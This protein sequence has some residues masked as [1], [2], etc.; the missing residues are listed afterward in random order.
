MS[1][2][3]D[4]AG[5]FPRKIAIA[6]RLFGKELHQK[7]LKWF[8]LRRAD[9]R[10]GE[11][12]V[13]AGVPS[14]HSQ[15]AQ[16]VNQIDIRLTS[17]R[18]HEQKSS[19]TYGEKVKVWLNGMVRAVRIAALERNRRNVLKQL[20]A[21]V[22]KS[23]SPNVLRTGEAHSAKQIAETIGSID[24]AIR[25]LRASTYVWARR[26]LLASSLLMILTIVVLLSF[27]AATQQRFGSRENSSSSLSEDQV[28]TL[29]TQTATFREQLLR[30][31]AELRRQE[32]ESTQQRI[33]AVE[34][35]HKEQRDRERAE[36]QK[37]AREQA[38][39]DE[40]ARRE[41]AD[42]EKQQQQLA[43]AEQARLEREEAEAEKLARE[44]AERAAAAERTRKEEERRTAQ[45]AEEKR[46]HEQAGHDTQNKP[47]NDL[48]R[49]QIEKGKASAAAMMGNLPKYPF[50]YDPE[51]LDKLYEGRLEEIG[52]NRL[53]LVAVAKAFQRAGAIELGRELISGITVD[54][55]T[56]V[57]MHPNYWMT[58]GI[59]DATGGLEGNWG[60]TTSANLMRVLRDRTEGKFSSNTGDTGKAAWPL[61]MRLVVTVDDSDFKK[62]MQNLNDTER[63]AVE[64]QIKELAAKGAKVY[65][66]DYG[67]P[68][69]RS[70]YND[71]H[72]AFW[73]GDVPILRRDLLAVSE[74]HPLANLGN[75]A[76]TDVPQ[77]LGEANRKHAEALA[78]A[79]KK[80]E[81]TP[82]VDNPR[83]L[84]WK[85]F[86]PGA[87]AIYTKNT[88]QAR[89]GQKQ[90]SGSGSTEVRTLQSIDSANARVDIDGKVQTFA[91]KVR[92]ERS[93]DEQKPPAREEVELNGKTF[94][95]N[96]RTRQ[97]KDWD[98]RVTTTTWTNDE[99][100]GGLVRLL[101]DEEDPNG[102]HILDD[103]TLQS[104]T[105]GKSGD[106][107][108]QPS[109]IPLFKTVFNFKLETGYYP[110]GPLVQ[111][112]DGNFYGTTSNGPATR[113]AGAA[114]AQGT[115]FKL[116]PDGELT[117]LHV[118]KGKDGAS[119]AGGLTKSRDGNFYGT[120]R[121]G[122]TRP[123]GKKTTT[124]RGTVFKITSGGQFT[125]LHT[126]AG[127]P[128]GCNPIGELIEAK[129]GNFYGI[130]REGGNECAGHSSYGCG[131]IFKITKHGELT[132]LHRF[133]PAIGEGR[134]PEA[135]LVQGRDGSFHGT[136]REG[137][138]AKDAYYSGTVFRITPAGEFITTHSFP[139][140]E[141]DG[142]R[143]KCGLAEG[144]D[145]S[146]YGVTEAGGDV[147]T[148]YK[149][150]GTGGYTILHR[151]LLL[152]GGQ[153]PG[154][155]L[156]RAKDGN[157][158]GS[159]VEARGGFGSLFRF[160]PPDSLTTLYVFGREFT[161]Q[162]NFGFGQGAINDKAKWAEQELKA[163]RDH[164]EYTDGS[165][166]N[167]LI[168]SADGNLW[169]TTEKG[170]IWDLG[171][172]FRINPKA[173]PKPSKNDH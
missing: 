165:Y 137:G 150:D 19:N 82:G 71:V 29:E 79:D 33:A 106:W 22:R 78:L 16:R 110:K 13:A 20:G 168:E 151:F 97:W 171:T 162:R 40:Q 144:S 98:R 164:P 4:I 152:E 111:A 66:A 170:G 21:A 85:G 1:P 52:P 96:R 69:A 121:E 46:Q 26:P 12:V 65:L 146:L 131:T 86:A 145:G 67:D 44:K 84:G 64:K 147:G 159:T 139:E 63:A 30:Q 124:G 80:V 8:D 161:E 93:P 128:D 149:L 17:L 9:C 105:G 59:L 141:G 156:I 119:P 112:S 130:T 95:C 18:Q 89:G 58:A 73:Y 115:V 77:T 104:Y 153:K 117:I 158:Y 43:A 11:K 160:T 90:P 173:A 132:I 42:R 45:L 88:W 103:I 136:T 7:K 92:D 87:S 154:A 157:Y 138:K 118:F 142:A 83:Y 114:G 148:I 100:P 60:K 53:D 129:D 133:N 25:E 68:Y 37:R 75:I 27:K 5:S 50:P 23:P 70:N 32:I 74:A 169:G 99:V 140:I 120:T 56:T 101:Q 116:T 3:E 24:G 49:S 155:A 81:A 108:G 167:E 54:G 14:E 6:T 163:G 48:L 51:L 125:S 107:S 72:L 109:G 36:V 28:K 123:S 2:R 113:D 135:G 172:I 31:Q 94:Q 166:P 143:P 39:K 35:Q 126:F 76:V 127:A 134:F 57:Q 55:L 102:L 62:P 47:A 15:F 91:A 61:K 34:R 41:Q 38:Q 122:G 10:L